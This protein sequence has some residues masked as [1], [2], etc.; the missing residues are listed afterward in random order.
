MKFI[1]KL[2]STS[3]ILHF[4][5]NKLAIFGIGAALMLVA[6]AFAV[7]ATQQAFASDR[8]DRSISNERCGSCGSSSQQNTGDTNGGNF[9]SGE[10]SFNSRS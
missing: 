8:V 6:T 1:G 7:V 4:V 9:N 10:R 3:L 5:M 2:L